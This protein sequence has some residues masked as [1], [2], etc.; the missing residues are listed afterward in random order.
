MTE[1]GKTGGHVF[2]YLGL[3]FICLITFGSYYIYDIPAALT[4]QNMITKWFGISSVEYATLYSVYSFPNMVI[5]FF[6]G[7]FIDSLFGLK[8]GSII[9]CCLVM[10]GQII[11][12]VASSLKLYWLAVVGRLVF[13]LGGESLSVAQSTFCATWFNGRSDI[14]LAFA[15]TLGFSRIGSAVNFQVSPELA[16]KVNF[17]FAVWF[18]AITCGV[19]FTSCIILCILDVIREKK[20]NKGAVANDPVSFKDIAK[21]PVTLWLVILAMVL[22]YVPLFVY[23]TVAQD[24][25]QRKFPHDKAASL[26]SIP[27]Y[28]AAPSPVIGFIIDRFGRNLSFMTFAAVLMVTAHIL[29]GYTYVTPY[30]GMVMMGI[31][32]ACMA[33]SIWVTFPALVPAKRLGTAYG[34][35]FAF[36]NA[37][38]ALTTLVINAI[39][40]KTQTGV[41]DS[42]EPIYNYIYSESIFVGIAAIGVAIHVILI[43][44]DMRNRC[45]NVPAAEMKQKVKDINAT[46]E[47][48]PLLVNEE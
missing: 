16:T 19:S 35:A 2:R 45:I 28:S 6:G 3:L 39:L 14:N 9:F 36:Q 37:A 4:N 25:L 30:V 27:Y 40:E 33:A 38:V 5:V 32:Y 29:L 48:S 43:F 12:S 21:F 13:G 18:G 24:F 31:S 15:I 47:T 26:T 11:F 44:I 23:I 42:G 34:L 17:P 1:E 7:F 20:D 41:D 8:K 10:A 46:S 22:F